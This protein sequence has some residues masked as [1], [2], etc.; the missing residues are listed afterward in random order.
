[1]TGISSLGAAALDGLVGSEASILDSGTAGAATTV[2][3]QWRAR[4]SA[5]T[6]QTP[7][8]PGTT[9]AGWLTSDVVNVSGVSGVSS[10]VLQMTFDPRI[11]LAWDGP[12]NGTTAAEFNGLYI[13]V[14]DSATQGWDNNTVGAGYSGSYANFMAA[15]LASNPSYVA[16]VGTWGVDPTT[17]H[18]WEVVSGNG[19]FA[20]VPE[21]STMA[22]LVAAA[23]ALVGCG[24]KRWRS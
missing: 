3:M 19:T 20:V 23:L 6:G 4:N 10:Y 14:Y 9:G 11:N 24:L 12:V 2:S 5:E 17:S 22:L 16:P 8:I 15:E 21:P 7:P 1:M 18:S 13:G